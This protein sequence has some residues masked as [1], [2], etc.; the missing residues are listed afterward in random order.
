MQIEV[1][2]TPKEVL[3]ELEE[4]FAREWPHGGELKRTYS[5]VAM[6]APPGDD[7][8]GRLDS[9]LWLLA[10]IFLTI[11]TLGLFLIVWLPIM[12]YRSR[13]RERVRADVRPVSADRLT[14]STSG[15]DKWKAA[16]DAWLKRT[17]TAAETSTDTDAGGPILPTY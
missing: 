17:Y 4:F 14:L 2:G 6:K 8:L 11:I 13:K 5:Y 15:T 3:D 16:L 1:N 7:F 12:W 10:G 9:R